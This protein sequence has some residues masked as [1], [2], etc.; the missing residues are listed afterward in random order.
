M[1]CEYS[2]VFVATIKKEKMK[3][4][5][6]KAAIKPILI[7][8]HV[9]RAGIF[10]SMAKGNATSKSDI[11]ILVELGDEISLLEFVGIKYEL[12]DLLGRKVDLVEYQAVKPR[13]KNRIMSEEIR[14][15]G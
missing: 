10:G 4:E 12:E 1:G 8:H 15:Y 14:I 2:F 6:I 11:D 7:R 9:K 3:I 13:L 5:E